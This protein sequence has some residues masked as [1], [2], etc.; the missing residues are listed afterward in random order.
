MGFFDFLGGNK[1]TAEL[2]K[3][4]SDANKLEMRKIFDS[5]VQ[6]SSEYK[7]VYAYSE[8]IGGANFAV[9]R[10]VTYKYRSFILGYTDKDL[11]IVFLEVSPDF[12]QVGEALT[13]RPEDVKKTNFTKMVGSYYLQY[14]N[15]FKKE[16]FNFFV[17]ETI[18]DILNL[19]WYDEQTFAYVDQREEHS[20]FV[21]FWNKFSK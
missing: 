20:S 17:P 4:K 1:K 2:D 9:L 8:D 16:F 11:S 7:I 3:N 12:S 18:D 14:G 5:K 13:Y 21:D 6:D 15:S 10:T 19:D